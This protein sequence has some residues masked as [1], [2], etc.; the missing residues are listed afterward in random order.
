MA[1]NDVPYLSYK[2]LEKMRATRVPY[3]GTEIYAWPYGNRDYSDR[4]FRYDQDTGVYDIYSGHLKSLDRI[5]A[6]HFNDATYDRDMNILK[7][8]HIGRMYP[9]NTFE[10]VA[11][12]SQGNFMLLESMFRTYFF[13]QKNIGGATTAWRDSKHEMKMHPLFHGLRVNMDTK[14]VHPSTH[15]TTLHPTLKIKE[16]KEY[17]EQFNEFLSVYHMFLD[18]IEGNGIAEIFDDIKMSGF[19]SDMHVSTLIE[20]LVRQRRYAD[21]AV[22]CATFNG[23]WAL[24]NPKQFYQ[25]I[26]N[27]ARSVLSKK[28]VFTHHMLY[29]KSGL[30]KYRP[31]PMGEK[32]S[33]TKWK[34]VIESH[35]KDMCRL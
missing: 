13:T 1:Y 16:A 24:R 34:I 10:F 7:A 22:L 27:S 3:R 6:G 33:A 25:H 15:Y 28:H 21:A 11:P 23:M 14:E 9:D 19:E 8:C 20:D 29:N 32:L 17:M 26:K 31:I 18:P 5:V 30:F 2:T 4:H 12:H 35:G